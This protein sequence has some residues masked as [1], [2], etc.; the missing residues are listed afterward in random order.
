MMPGFDSSEE[1]TSVASTLEEG[2]QGLDSLGEPPMANAGESIGIV[3]Q[4][5]GHLIQASAGVNDGLHK[6]AENV[7]GSRRQQ[8][9]DD[10]T[11]RNHMPNGTR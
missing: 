9:R 5:L 10:E 3:A 11:A 6:A 1:L 8:V 7:R 4:A 2:A